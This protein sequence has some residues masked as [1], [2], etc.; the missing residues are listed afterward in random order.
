MSAHKKSN[1]WRDCR[2]NDLDNDIEQF[3]RNDGGKL[4]TS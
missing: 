3:S 2:N 1:G 4:R